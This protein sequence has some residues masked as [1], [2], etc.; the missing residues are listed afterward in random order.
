MKP[1]DYR[2]LVKRALGLLCIFLLA[3][4]ALVPLLDSPDAPC[5]RQNAGIADLSSCTFDGESTFELD[6]K[7]QFY[8]NRLL[9]PQTPPAG[10]DGQQ[11][12][13]SVPS[14][15]TPPLRG[16]E[17]ERYGFATYRLTLI[18][19][20]NI[21]A[22]ALKVNNIR[23]ASTLYIN[24]RIAGSSGLTGT[25]KQSSEPRNQPYSVS[26]SSS[27]GRAELL[28]HV[29]NFSYASGG[30][31]EPL[32][33]GT[34]EAIEAHEQ[35]SS[36]FDLFMV[37]GFSF[38]GVYL[39][40]QGLH[41]RE[42]S[43][44]LHLAMYCFTI[45]VYMLT[46]SEKLL[47]QFFPSISYEW[48]SKL[49][50]LSGVAGLYFVS[51]YTR[52][53]FPALYSRTF[54][55]ITFAYS[56]GFGVITLAS[57]VEV[58]S[59]AAGI[60]FIFSFLSV[61]YTFYVMARAAWQRETGS[62]YLLIGVIAAIMFTL[63]LASN[64]F[65]GTY[66]YAIPPVAGPIF[67]LA[68]GLFLSARQAHAYDTIKQL[69]EQLE[70][71]DR[72]KDEFLLKTANEL[73]T[74]LGAINNISLS[75]YE[76]AGGTLSPSQ[77]EDM[78]LILG[79]GRRLAF[80]VRDILD[81][82]QIKRQLI[83]L[84]LK[85]VDI[86]AV[87]NIVIEV[88]QLLNKRGKVRIRNRIAPGEYLVPADEHRLMQILYN[89]LDNAL[90]FT[91]R[92]S[93]VFEA[94][95]DGEFVSVTVTDTGRGIPEEQLESIFR[96][97]EQAN[98]G[99]L[100]ES[101]GLGLGLP[102]TRK[103]VELHGGSIAVSSAPGRGSSFKFTIPL[104]E[105]VDMA[106]EPQECELLPAP[107]QHPPAARDDEWKYRSNP[108][109][110]PAAATAGTAPRILIVDD[111]YAGLKS[112]TNL[113][114]LENY[115]IT[116]MRSGREALALLTEDRNFDLCIIDV[117]MPEMSGLELCR[118]IRRTY[119]PLDLPI[120]MATAGQQLHFNESAFLAGANDFIHKPYAWSD[121]KGRVKTLVQL[122]R[123][124]TDR[125]SSEIAMLRAQIKPHFLYN[126]INTIIWMS[127][128]DNEKTRQLLYDLSQFLRGSFDF[129][130]QETAIPFEKELE[131]IE[132]YLSLEQARFGKRLNARYNIE[133]S[134]FAL[135]PLIV[136]PIIENAVRHG[137]M[138]KIGGGTVVLSTRQEADAILITVSDDGK[139]M[140]SEQLSSWMRDDYI[141]PGGQGT[142]IG[143]RN[144]NR[145]LL[146]Q[147][148]HP[149]RLTQ[150]ADGGIE[151]QITIPW[152]EEAS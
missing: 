107:V 147:F 129:S 144:I 43:S 15:W 134:D 136:Q 141:S 14:D 148:G 36:S 63:T 102:I 99:D 127:T 112:L 108:V 30:I 87:A 83:T 79:T 116:S 49:Q 64:L 150:R 74:P 72:D 10:K 103:L 142:G 34:P 82:E 5:A 130:N 51:R 101:G 124:V 33:I 39:F 71:R 4:A 93:V 44:S 143:L 133:V 21:P 62:Y 29:S 98:D 55:R 88:F 109:H 119:T 138:E 137:L 17:Y 89:L 106:G 11:K 131:L 128:R 122:R 52:S 32:R 31:A 132:A 146:K 58:Y 139:G 100:P 22:F 149:L 92:G 84:H 96:D 90:K 2:L 135:P 86:Q 54:G 37:A 94:A 28:I 145:R 13:I 118:L 95:L 41:R 115:S 35:R 110:Q 75:L 85:P 47:F 80:M 97:Y 26:F 12:F 9:E 50:L 7:W 18:L 16:T 48:F 38:I 105:G 56:F 81:Y 91:D 66:F 77:R 6:G 8:W 53:L 73:R 117:M 151:V 20:E 1:F 25:D 140:N 121:L 57:S 24:G 46:H 61:C 104:R 111:D 60:V 3:A 40:G 120:L 152:K 27:H 70:R 78:R 114:S 59:R 123:S 65:L 68:E 113:L 42:D 76:G 126:A 125:L 45:A 23:N 67:V 69:S 19:P